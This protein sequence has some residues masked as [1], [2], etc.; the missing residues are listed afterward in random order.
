VKSSRRRT[1][2]T[3]RS[4]TS[5]HPSPTAPARPPERWDLPVEDDPGGAGSASDALGDDGPGREIAGDDW[6]G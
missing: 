2:V 6:S 3:S 5:P 4:F 1:A